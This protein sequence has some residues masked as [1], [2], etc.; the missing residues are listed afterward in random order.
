MK[1]FHNLTLL[2]YALFL[3][4]N[5]VLFASAPKSELNNPAIEQVLA[6][7]KELDPHVYQTLLDCQHASGRSCLKFITNQNK[8]SK[9]TPPSDTSHGYP[10]ISI[11]KQ[12]VDPKKLPSLRKLLKTKIIPAYKMHLNCVYPE[13]DQHTFYYASLAKE[14]NPHIHDELLHYSPH[15]FRKATIEYTGPTIIPH[16]PC[17]L[18]V[19]P[20]EKKWFLVQADDLRDTFHA[21]YDL[22]R[23]TSE[24]YLPEEEREH[25]LEII[26]KF[27]PGLHAE[28]SNL[29][30]EIFRHF[31]R[32]ESSTNCAVKKSSTNGL[33]VFEFGSEIKTFDESWQKL[34]IGHELG[35]Y[36]LE[37]L[38]KPA[39]PHPFLEERESETTSSPDK[40]PNK[41]L[42]FEETFKNARGRIHEYEADRFSVLNLGADPEAGIK[43][44]HKRM[45][46]LGE[47]EPS[48]RK[49][50]SET[51][52]P[53]I[54][55]IK[56]LRNLKK[57]VELQ[58][59]RGTL[60]QEPD[61]K[62]IARSY[63]ENR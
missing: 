38:Q 19:V 54:E 29:G 4:G 7:I 40:H 37:H 8:Q 31:Q 51:H 6:V 61:W 53:D 30:D 20:A 60:L 36:A 63:L 27:A 18:I 12:L 26:R 48:H 46:D 62:E 14:I 11:E 17:P 49:T 13:S 42:P 55:R 44:R 1:F 5:T 32:H 16:R 24:L 50:F 2:L 34:I 9:V 58:K 47:T 35:H 23:R 28:L 57:E 25:F 52:P 21:W 41:F 10:I 45:H 43:W 39:S 59:A 15:C 22:Y 56:H 3:L 33:P